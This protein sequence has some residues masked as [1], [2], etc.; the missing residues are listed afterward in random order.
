MPDAGEVIALAAGP[1][2]L[3]VW[4]RVAQ[5]LAAVAVASAAAGA[6]LGRA[7]AGAVAEGALVALAARPHVPGAAHAHA[8]LQGALPLAALRAPLLRPGLT[9]AAA[10]RLNFHLQHVTEPHR[11]YL[12]KPSGFFTRRETYGHIERD[13]EERIGGCWEHRELCR[14][15][16]KYM[17]RTEQEGHRYCLLFDW[18]GGRSLNKEQTLPW[19]PKLHQLHV[20][21]EY[22]LSLPYLPLSHESISSDVEKQSHCYRWL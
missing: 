18:F 19:C 16:R 6:V 7:P 5:A 14:V 12:D 17:Q 8:A 3:S 15:L 2:D 9:V 21:G 4:G 22:F 1:V 13:L 10:E 11:F 20:L